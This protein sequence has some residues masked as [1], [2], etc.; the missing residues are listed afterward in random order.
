MIFKKLYNNLGARP[1]A[2]YLL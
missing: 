1:G 2:T